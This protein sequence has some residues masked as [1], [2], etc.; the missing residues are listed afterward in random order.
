MNNIESLNHS[1]LASYRFICS[2]CEIQQL[3]GDFYHRIN[4]KVFCKKC[5]PGEEE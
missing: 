3:I 4:N 1:G 5:D 2:K